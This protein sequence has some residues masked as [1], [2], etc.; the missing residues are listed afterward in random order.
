MIFKKS[1]LPLLTLLL[2]ITHLDVQAAAAGDLNAA[3]AVDV[4][5]NPIVQL[6]TLLATNTDEITALSRGEQF[7]LI[8]QLKQLQALEAQ[9]KLM[10]S[11]NTNG[12]N[13]TEEKEKGDTVTNAM[14]ALKRM[15]RGEFASKH[16]RDL[17]VSP[18]IPGLLTAVTGGLSLTDRISS[19]ARTKLRTLA[20]VSGVV[21]AA[22]GLYTV[23]RT[24]VPPYSKA[25][26]Q[27]PPLLA[28]G[29]RRQSL[30]SSSNSSSQ[31]TTNNVRK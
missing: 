17:K 6:S 21:T 14:D 23:A 11:S 19:G 20:L 16:L 18:V 13:D 24:I 30:S 7:A 10:A 5:G 8:M 31:L 3:A 12:E 25:A 29:S 28:A 2:S 1:L 9:L 26:A 4:T 15:P 27:T 22:S